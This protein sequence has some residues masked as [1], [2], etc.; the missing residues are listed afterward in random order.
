MNLG[1]FCVFPHKLRR[2]PISPASPVRIADYNAVVTGLGLGHLFI[3][4]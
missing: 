4:E 1:A 2:G 3:R